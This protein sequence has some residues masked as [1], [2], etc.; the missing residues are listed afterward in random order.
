MVKIEVL[1]H[2]AD[3]FMYL[4]GYLWVWD[5]QLEREL[6][7]ELAEQ[8]YGNVLIAGYGFGIVQEYL[9]KN[10]KVT[11]ITTVEK[12]SEVIDYCKR[13]EIVGEIIFGDFYTISPSKEFDCVI[14]DIC[15]DIAPKFLP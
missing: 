11:S 8:A 5:V 13:K 7:Q 14:G 6:Q 12:Y 1:E 2:D 10:K 9:A 15:P 3:R 4:D